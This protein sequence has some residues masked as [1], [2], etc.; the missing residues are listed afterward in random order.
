METNNSTPVTALCALF[1]VAIF[2]AC[3]TKPAPPVAPQA[4]KYDADADTSSRWMAGKKRIQSQ[5]ATIYYDGTASGKLAADGERWVGTITGEYLVI[6]NTDHIM[7][8]GGRIMSK[9]PG[10]LTISTDGDYAT[11][12][13]VTKTG[14]GK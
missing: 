7:P 6:F 13:A 3:A 12:G 4:P 10:K 8:A 9:S 11:E 14:S 1:T 5:E 2:S